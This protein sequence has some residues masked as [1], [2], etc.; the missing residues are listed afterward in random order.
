MHLIVIL[1]F[2][3]GDKNRATSAIG[4]KKILKIS[5][6]DEL[7]DKEA[8]Q[9]ESTNFNIKEDILIDFNNEIIVD[10]TKAQDMLANHQDLAEINFETQPNSLLDIDNTPPT[11]PEKFS[12]TEANLFIDTK[13]ES[14]LEPSTNSL[15]ELP[16]SSKY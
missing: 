16:L 14:E 9:F 5:S 10:A 2:K 3:G 13:A 7:D 15:I 1:Y 4:N 12:P 11:V 8:Q 6:I